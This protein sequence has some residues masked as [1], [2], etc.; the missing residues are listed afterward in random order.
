MALNTLTALAIILLIIV[1]SESEQAKEKKTGPL[2]KLCGDDFSN[3]FETCCN[4]DQA[5]CR[6][7]VVSS[8]EGVVKALEKR[9][10]YFGWRVKNLCVH[11]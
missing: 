2:Y 6:S 7:S 8:S 5:T 3:A 1:V 4:Y 9:G 10:G 11:A